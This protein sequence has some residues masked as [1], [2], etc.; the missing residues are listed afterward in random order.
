M[1]Q[2]DIL[3]HVPR[4]KSKHRILEHNKIWKQI[5]IQLEWEFIRT[6]KRPANS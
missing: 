4:M 5:C 1:N 3:Q 6:K 2:I